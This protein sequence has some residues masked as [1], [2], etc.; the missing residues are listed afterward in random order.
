MFYPMSSPCAP[1]FAVKGPFFHRYLSDFPSGSR[2]LLPWWHWECRSPHKCCAKVGAI[3]WNGPGAPQEL[4]FHGDFMGI[5]WGFHGDFMGISWGFNLISWNFMWFVGH[6]C[7][8]WGIEVPTG[9]WRKGKYGNMMIHYV[10]FLDTWFFRQSHRYGKHLWTE[11]TFVATSR[12]FE[13]HE[14]MWFKLKIWEVGCIYLVE[15]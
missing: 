8:K 2:T 14:R 12:V 9:Y 6:S 10:S 4:W 3:W 1:N 13:P 5:S 7:W 11:E 15:F